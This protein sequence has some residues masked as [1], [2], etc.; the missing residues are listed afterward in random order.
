MEFFKIAII[1]FLFGILLYRINTISYILGTIGSIFSLLCGLYSYSHPW[2]LSLKYVTI[3]VDKISSIFLI[4]IFFCFS[5]IAYYSIDFGKLFKKNM[6]LLINLIMLSLLLTVVSFDAITFLISFEIMNIAL[7]FSILE[8]DGSQ[9]E[10]FSFLAFSEFSTIMFIIGFG[11]LFS[12][13]HSFLFNMIKGSKIIFLFLFLGFIIKMDIIPF[14]TW[15]GN[16][17]SKAPSNIT[18][19]LSVPLTLI[20]CYGIFRLFVLSP[21][22]QLIFGIIAV[23]WGAITSFWG[24]LQSARARSLKK[25]PGYSTIENNGLILSTIGLSYYLLSYPELHTFSEFAILTSFFIIIAHA[26]SKT[27]LFLSIGHA[28]EALQTETIDDVRGIYKNVSRIAGIGII[29]C[30]LSLTAFIP[31]IGYVSEWMI[32]ETFFQSYKISPMTYKLI[33]TISGILIALAGGLS[34]FGMKK[35]IGFSA[36]NTQLIKIKLREFKSTNL[37]IAQVLMILAVIFSGVFSPFIVKILGYREFL[38]GLLIVPKGFLI[39]SGRPIFGVISPTMF[40]VVGGLMI[41]ISILIFKLPNKNVKFVKPW[42]GGEE[43]K[44][45][46]QFSTGAYSFIVEYILGKVY[47]T[48]EIITPKMAHVRSKDFLE[49]IYSALEKFFYLISYFVSRTIMNGKIAFYVFYIMLS[50]I[51]TLILFKVFSLHLL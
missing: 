6:A 24:G 10:A 16:T 42:V 12:T 18:A 33:V 38:D 4:I 8:K 46:E 23:I 13:T 41:I 26:L 39:V 50:F 21:H 34:S 31:L 37:K 3:Y 25:L 29:I 43:I 45:E 19:I 36:L 1:F 7:F 48:K 44:L 5:I 49:Y 17:Y 22:N 9:N 14:H 2:N 51:V 47:L 28:K 35:L 20:G 30:G 27:G 40:F 15:I 32:L 11:I